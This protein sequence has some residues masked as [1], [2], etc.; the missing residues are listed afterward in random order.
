[1]FQYEFIE[2][3]VGFILIVFC[4]LGIVG[5]LLTIAHRPENTNR[6]GNLVLSLAVF[7]LA[8]LIGAL[9]LF[10]IPLISKK[11]QESYFLVKFLPFL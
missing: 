9:F 6:A 3:S 7:D 10:G 2:E 8:F 4:C 11:F 1:M 5:N